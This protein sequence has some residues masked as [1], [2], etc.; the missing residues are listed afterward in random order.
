M[1]MKDKIIL[2]CR[3]EAFHLDLIVERKDLVLVCCF[4]VTGLF[5][6]TLLITVLIST[7]CNYFV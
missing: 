4:P 2:L 5:R 1:V 6:V 7:G 3:V